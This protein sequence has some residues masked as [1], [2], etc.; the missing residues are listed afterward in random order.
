M[1]RV[2]LCVQ[3]LHTVDLN[4][5]SSRP[6]NYASKFCYELWFIFIICVCGWKRFPNPDI[7]ES[8]NIFDAIIFFFF[9]FFLNS[10]HKINRGC[11]HCRRRRR[12]RRKKD[13]FTLSSVC[14]CLCVGWLNVSAVSHWNAP[15]DAKKTRLKRNSKSKDQKKKETKLKWAEGEERK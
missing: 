6:R 5:T 3:I 11:P 15:M 12:R 10:R 4:R 14:V 8:S 9:L 13:I 2:F 1:I 7:E